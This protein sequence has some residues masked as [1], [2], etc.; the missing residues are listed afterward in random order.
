MLQWR[1]QQA[2][3][4]PAPPPSPSGTLVTSAM[5]GLNN[6][7]NTCFFNSSLQLLLSCDPL[8]QLLLQPGSPL[9]KGPIGFALQQAA[10]FAAGAYS[11]WAAAPGRL[12][13]VRPAL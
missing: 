9:A 3:A 13:C 11:R 2:A 4:V 12:L 1:A 6:L 10:M 8:Q 5:V 7:G